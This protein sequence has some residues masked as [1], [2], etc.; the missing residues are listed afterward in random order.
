MFID[1]SG[2]RSEGFQSIHLVFGMPSRQISTTL[3][4][5][6]ATNRP[7]TDPWPGL[8]I[9][10]HIVRDC[11]IS[12]RVVRQRKLPIKADGFTAVACSK[13]DRGMQII[14]DARTSAAAAIDKP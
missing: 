12:K 5:T 7:A 6:D 8:K 3:V 2:L 1:S 11:A 9:L 14:A 13:Y 4:P 10:I